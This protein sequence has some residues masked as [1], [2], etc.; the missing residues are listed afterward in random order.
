MVTLENIYQNGQVK[1][2]KKGEKLFSRN[3][4]VGEDAIF[5]IKQGLVKLLIFKKDRTELKIYL[6]DGDLAGVAEVYADSPRVTESICD[7][8]VECYIWNKSNFILTVSMIWELSLY[9]IKS[10]SVFLKI[11]NSEFV[12]KENIKF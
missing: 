1:K 8:D 12:E 7:S 2:F 3:E 11:I 9:T 10:L 5:F 4:M 6:K